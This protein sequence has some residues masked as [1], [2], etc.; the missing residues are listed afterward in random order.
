MMN[1][2]GSGLTRLSNN[3]ANEIDPSWHPNGR[4]IVFASDEAQKEGAKT[5]DYDIWIMQA[6]GTRRTQLTQ[7][8][9]RDDSPTFDRHGRTIVFRSNRGGA[10]NLFSFQPVMK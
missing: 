10:W 2:D 5:R 1:I 8:I 9:S 4:L 6:D 7:N 3:D